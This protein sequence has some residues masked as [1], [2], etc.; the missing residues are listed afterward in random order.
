MC[1][2]HEVLVMRIWRRCLGSIYLKKKHKKKM[3]MMMRWGFVGVS[4]E[5]RRRWGP[6]LWMAGLGGGR[7]SIKN[8]C[9]HLDAWRVEE[10]SISFVFQ[11]LIRPIP[12]FSIKRNVFSPK[13][14]IKQKMTERGGRGE[15]EKTGLLQPISKCNLGISYFRAEGK[16]EGW[17]QREATGSDRERYK[18]GN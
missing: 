15:E 1:A 18:R 3:M 2:L 12:P 14:W 9:S 11:E 16:P 6:M 4:D 7:V 8:G 5:Q 17:W 10:K 13:H